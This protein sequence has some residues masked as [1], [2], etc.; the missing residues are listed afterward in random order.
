MC[1]VVDV[2]RVE[3]LA[4]LFTADQHFGHFNI[5]RHCDRPFADSVEMDRFMTERW[6]ERVGAGDTVYVVGDLMFR[7]RVHPSVYLDKL[8][9]RKHLIVGNHDKQWMKK[10]ELGDYFESVSQMLTIGDGA[11]KV[12]LCHY[13]MIS[14]DGVRSG[15]FHVYGHIHNNTG[16]FYWPLLSRMPNALNAGVEVNDYYPVTIDEMIVNNEKHKERYSEKNGEVLYKQ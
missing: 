15:A 4:I 9:G 5:I 10:V 6:N 16:D 12:T 13:P 2:W 3:D 8:K 7:M 1:L 14:W 11:H